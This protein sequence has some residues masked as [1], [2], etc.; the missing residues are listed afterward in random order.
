MI[1]KIRNIC[2]CFTISPVVILVLWT[3]LGAMG[4]LNS[5]HI[6]ET[7]ME[8]ISMLGIAVTATSATC[9]VIAQKKMHKTEAYE[10][11]RK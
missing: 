2:I 7:I 11:G 5:I 10:F 6:E 1:R 9:A 8:I 4:S 3:I